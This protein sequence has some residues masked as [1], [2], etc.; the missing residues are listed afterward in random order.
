LFLSFWLNIGEIVAN[1]D[2]ISYVLAKSAQKIHDY[3]LDEIVFHQGRK[4]LMLLM[5]EK[6]N[7]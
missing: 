4:E 6:R 2:K 3:V 1:I 7:W 5:E